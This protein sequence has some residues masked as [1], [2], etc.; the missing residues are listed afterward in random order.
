M[1]AWTHL[2]PAIGPGDPAVHGS[3]RRTLGRWGHLR[4]VSW[5]G[6]VAFLTVGAVAGLDA[7]TAAGAIWLGVTLVATLGLLVGSVAALTGRTQRVSAG[8]T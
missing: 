2:V 5:N 4:F 8:R 1:G 7:V 6:A 3:Q